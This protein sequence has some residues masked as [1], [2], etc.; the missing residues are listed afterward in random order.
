[1]NYMEYLNTNANITYLECEA[2]LNENDINQLDL[3]VPIFIDLGINGH[4]YWKVLS[5]NYTNNGRSSTV[6]LQKII[7]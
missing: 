2:Y 3:S 1:M 4:S 6:Q 7:V 5:I